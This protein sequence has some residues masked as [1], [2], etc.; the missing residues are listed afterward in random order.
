MNRATLQK[1]YKYIYNNDID[2]DLLFC[3]PVGGHT[4]GM[5][6]FQTVDDFFKEVGLFWT[7]CV[8]VCTNEAVTMTGHTAGFHARMRSA[9]D[10]PITFTQ[11]MIPVY[12]VLERLL[13]LKKFS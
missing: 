9:S 10:I 2:K 12:T 1:W 7:D 6:I 8:G 4:T 11:C 13:L 5:V 3:Q